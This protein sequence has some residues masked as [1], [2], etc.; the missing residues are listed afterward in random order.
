MSCSATT[1]RCCS[2]GF[3]FTRSSIA[4]NHVAYIEP[5]ASPPPNP[6]S[7][8]LPRI[9]KSCSTAF[10]DELKRF[11][12]LWQ[13]QRRTQ[14]HTKI[15]Q[16]TPMAIPAYRSNIDSCAPP[17]VDAAPSPPP[18]PVA[19]ACPPPPADDEAPELGPT[20][21][22]AGSTCVAADPPP[23]VA[24]TGRTHSGRIGLC[25]SGSCLTP[26]GTAQSWIPAPGVLVH[27]SLHSH[28]A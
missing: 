22:P 17:T 10:S 5:C 6:S 7:P 1:L 9:S 15:K 20:T 3:I 4:L 12:A 8:V 21:S 27:P 28:V 13:C 23:S 2:R 26:V 11:C 16:S 14:Q 19:P 25:L 18:L 24:N